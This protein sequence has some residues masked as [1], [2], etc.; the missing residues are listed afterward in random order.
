MNGKL[1]VDICAVEYYATK[2]KYE[3]MAYYPMDAS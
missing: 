3:V 2:N 1:S